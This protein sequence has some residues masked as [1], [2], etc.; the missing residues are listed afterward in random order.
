MRGCLRLS[1]GVGAVIISVLARPWVANAQTAVWTGGGGADT[2]FS[3]GANWAGGV[4]PPNDGSDTLKLNQAA[5][6]TISV[7]SAA[8]G[9]GIFLKGAPGGRTQY[10]ISDGGGS[11]TIGGG[12][13]SAASP[14]NSSVY[15][16]ASIVLSANQT[17]NIGFINQEGGVISG[18]GGLTTTG[19]AYMFGDN[20]F[21]G[22]LN[23]LAGTFFVGSG[24]SAGTGTITIGD[25]ASLD[26]FF[27]ADTLPNAIVLGP[28]VTFGTASDAPLTLTGSISVANTAT[29]VNLAAYTIV[30]LGGNVTGPPST[31]LTI[32]GANSTLPAD[33]GSQL[34][35]GGA[36]SQI[37]GLTVANAQLILAPTG[38]PAASFSSLAGSGLQVG[39]PG[40]SS[41]YLGLDGTFATS[42]AVSNFISTFGPNIGPAINGTLGFD[43]L[44]SPGTPQTFTDPIDLSPFTSA[45]FL[46]LGSATSAIVAG[47]I[48]PGLI[49]G[50]ANP[51][52]AFGGGGGTL[53]VTSNLAD[54]GGSNLIMTLAPAPVTVL[55]QGANTYTLGTV[56]EG[57]VLI[58]DSPPP[59]TGFI[60][61]EGG[62]VGETERSAYAN[63]QQFVSR[64]DLVGAAGV[65]GFDSTDPANPRTVADPVSLSGFSGSGGLF[66]GTSTVVTFSGMITPAAGAYQLTGVKGGQL[67]VASPLNTP[68]ST[69]TVGLS[70][71]IEANG[72]TSSVTLTGDNSALNSV[73]FNS[74]SLFINNTHALGSG[75][76]SVPDMAATTV[77][78]VLA[79][80]GGAVSLSNPISLGAIDAGQEPGLTVG[81]P[82]TPDQLVLNGVISDYPSQQGFLAIDGAVTLN[83][84]NTYSGGTAITGNGNALL[85]V[86]APTALGSGPVAVQSAGT[87]APTGGNVGI[88]NPIALSDTLTLGQAGNLNLLTLTGVIGGNGGLDVLS[89]VSLMA[90]NAY[91]GTTF[92]SNSTVT[93]GDSASLGTGA[94]TLSDSLLI[95]EGLSPTFTDLAGDA[96]SSIELPPNAVLTLFTDQ[97]PG[98]PVTF[99]GTIGGGSG[100]QLVKTGSGAEYLGGSSTYGG[101]TSVNAGALIAGNATALGTGPV[102][103]A[104]GASLEVDSGVKVTNPVAL[105]PGSTIGG[106]GNFS[107]TGGLSV[108]GGAIVS[109]GLNGVQNA[110]VGTLTF[111]TPVA[112]GTGG[113]YHF[114]LQNASGGAG[115]G[116]DTLNLASTALTVT[117]TPAQPF[118][119]SLESIDPATGAPGM[120]LFNP[121]QSYSWTLLAAGSVS[122][123]SLADFV[124]TT[125]GFVN[126][127]SGGNFWVTE[128]ANTLDLNFTPVPEPSTW[129]LMLV[130]LAAVGARLRRRRR[131]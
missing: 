81:N 98:Q 70:S 129:A 2:S 100:D 8:D 19:S 71:P 79:A 62:Y 120:A 26:T 35:I 28:D 89:N 83:G 104:S 9:A 31:T 45:G 63:A 38:G 86:G 56:S 11:L 44:A 64:F 124:V 23:V 61:L 69:L 121:L 106:F 18:P 40:G 65:I 7:D 27:S 42:G 41:A 55:L 20:T 21:T 39:I 57:G 82:S 131:A 48:T 117:A 123:F 16:D 114:D 85:L 72:S 108:A 54:F 77:A 30:T 22:G 90:A 6:A 103:V 101:G 24:T 15:F 29:T 107:P 74:G 102:T 78:P 84:A 17:W 126:L 5:N 3:D 80:F 93:L 94:V 4:A 88:A 109:P 127:P 118:T 105:S 125:T 51:S 10:F 1:L 32:S 14:A 66:L 67:T 60:S 47:Q 52:F 130:G 95:E 33:G 34:V 12:G 115:I 53:T 50:S 99:S 92:V 76:V 73:T 128:G 116:Y 113:V 25:G 36:L 43:T 58:F 87:L 96:S 97:S 37:S 68:G 46:G 112:F 59:A 119:I 91:T 122:G 13:I 49:G 75:T 110:Y 111:G